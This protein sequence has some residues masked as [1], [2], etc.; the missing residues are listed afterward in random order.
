M[1]AHELAALLET[2]ALTEETIA[3][4]LALYTLRLTRDRIMEASEGPDDLPSVG[5]LQE[6]AA[7]FVTDFRKLDDRT[8]ELCYEIDPE[9]YMI[10]EG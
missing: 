8:A 3:E 9:N 7:C 4:A 10:T 1:T 2:D 5:G 6:S